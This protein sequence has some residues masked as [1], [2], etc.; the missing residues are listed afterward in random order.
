MGPTRKR[1]WSSWIRSVTTRLTTWSPMWAHLSKQKFQ[2]I[3]ENQWKRQ[4]HSSLSRLGLS[5]GASNSPRR[6]AVRL[7][8]VN[9]CSR[10][11]ADLIF[12]RGG[13]GLVIV[14]AGVEEEGS[15][16]RS[17]VDSGNGN[18]IGSESRGMEI[19]RNIKGHE[20]KDSLVSKVLENV[21]PELD[22]LSN[23][24]CS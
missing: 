22:S 9:I 13:R 23:A 19:N 14:I 15:G 17:T 18:A 1:G 24:H 6:F 21:R 4:T 8:W 12:G 3:D 16:V 7:L 2:S 11:C 10:V 5:G 20:T